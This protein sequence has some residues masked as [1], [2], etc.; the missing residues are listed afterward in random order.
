[1]TDIFAVRITGPLSPE[2]VDRLASV[3]PQETRMLLG[4][5]RL[6]ADRDRKLLAESLIRDLLRSRLG[7]QLSGAVFARNEYGKPYIKEAPD[8][9]FNLSHSGNWVVCVVHD[10]PA[11]IDVEQLLPIDMNAIA[12]RYFADREQELLFGLPE[13]ERLR[14]F[15]ALWTCKESYMKA[16]GLG[17]SLPL[18]DFY[19]VVRGRSAHAYPA[20]PGSLASMPRPMR[21]CGLDGAV[22][23]VCAEEGALFP[24]EP[25][26]LTSDEL[27]I[28][29]LRERD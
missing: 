26:L 3:L 16:E 20:Y 18:R 1:M 2:I 14:G 13:T 24:E 7:R 8:F 10:R 17:L 22:M 4:R 27:V 29:C 9:H 28:T 19:V 11:G 5:Y 21:L 12:S 15:Y 6:Q 23:A 25:I